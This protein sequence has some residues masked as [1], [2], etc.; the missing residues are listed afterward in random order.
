MPPIVEKQLPPIRRATQSQGGSSPNSI[1][2]R[3]TPIGF[4]P[5]DGVRLLIYGQSGTGK[6]TVAST[7]PGPILWLISS[8]G[9]KPGELRSVDTP[10]NRKRISKFILQSTNDFKELI[11]ELKAIDAQGEKP[12]TTVVLDHASGF[13]DLVLKEVL[14][15]SQLP[16]QKTWGMAT[17]Q[18]WG[19]VGVQCKELFR[20]FLSLGSNTVIIAQERVFNGSDEGDSS[21][22]V[23]PTVGPNLSPSIAGWLTPSCDYIIQAHKRPRIITTQVDGPGGK[24]MTQ[25]VKGKGVIYAARTGPDETYITKFRIPKGTKLPE[26]IEDPDYDQIIALI[27]GGHPLQQ[28]S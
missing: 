26:Y 20:L 21:G 15:L 9:D 28:R 24:K 16:A 23:R 27:R 13:Q 19:Q 18:N 22:V 25:T 6:T 14:G 10:E 7:F 3:V 5:N 1:L 17:Q 12:Y 2:S 11:G 8:G 4:D